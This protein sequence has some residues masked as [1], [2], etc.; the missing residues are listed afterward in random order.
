MNAQPAFLSKCLAPFQSKG[1][2]NLIPFHSAPRHD[3][4][5]LPF[6][7]PPPESNQP[8]PICLCKQE[9]KVGGRH[10][11]MAVLVFMHPPTLFPE[12]FQ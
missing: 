11:A 5:V 12:T 2:F 6:S 4:H 8:G 10:L 1:T 7:R 9:A 3:P